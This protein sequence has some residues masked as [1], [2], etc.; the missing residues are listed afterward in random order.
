MS[1]DIKAKVFAEDFDEGSDRFYDETWAPEPREIEVLNL[2]MRKEYAQ[3][4]LSGKKN[5]EVRSWSQH[6]YN[7]LYDKDVDLWN[8]QHE[9]DSE[10]MF[11]R[12]VRYSDPIRPVMAIH[13]H[14]Y[15]NTWY[16]DVECTFNSEIVCNPEQVKYVQEAFDCHEF[17]DVLEEY[18][19]INEGKAKEEQQWPM[20]FYFVLGDVLDTN[21]PSFEKK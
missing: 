19:K 16:L 4:I 5:I 21:L 12:I 13:F 2:I 3:E 1:E 18:I 20:Y 15:N 8:A 9:N 11:W 10:E 17:D 7:R 14:N 6:Y